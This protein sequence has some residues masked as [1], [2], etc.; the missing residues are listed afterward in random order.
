MVHGGMN[1][2]SLFFLTLCLSVQVIYSDGWTSLWVLAVSKGLL[3][4]T[5]TGCMS[6]CLL[7]RLS[8]DS[9]NSPVMKSPVYLQ[10]ASTFGSKSR[11]TSFRQNYL[12]HV[13]TST[14]TLCTLLMIWLCPRLSILGIISSVN[15]DYRLMKL[16]P[17]VLFSSTHWNLFIDS[18][19]FW[20][21]N[22]MYWSYSET[23][24]NS[25]PFSQPLPNM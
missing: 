3:S 14:E 24:P 13:I 10:S 21:S 6:L 9:F 17:P 12:C 15:T 5:E 4:V 18:C 1:S 2:P 8:S 22:Q 25:L 16:T 19:L 20:K 7:A 23:F 11:C